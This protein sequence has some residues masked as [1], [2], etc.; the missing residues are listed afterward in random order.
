MLEVEEQNMELVEDLSV[1]YPSLYLGE[2]FQGDFYG[3]N[4]YE[5]R[6][7]EILLERDLVVFREPLIANVDCVPDFF[8]YNCKRGSGKL[9]EITLMPKNGNGK[10]G[11]R[12]KMRKERQKESL[13]STGIPYV[14]L[15]REELEKVRDYCRWDL[16]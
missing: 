12:T 7:V 6:F 3:M 5:A 14:I 13:A 4:S 8:V 2:P 1:K 9:V 11:F 16:F 15:Y 10:N